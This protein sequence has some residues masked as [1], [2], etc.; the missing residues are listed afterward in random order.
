[1]LSIALFK[2]RG[3]ARGVVFYNLGMAISSTLNAVYHYTFKDPSIQLAIL[4]GIFF[5]ISILFL[6]LSFKYINLSDLLKGSTTKFG[7]FNIGLLVYLLLN[8]AGQQGQQG[9]WSDFSI[10]LFL[11]GIGLFFM[12]KL[13]KINSL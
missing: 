9:E 8:L 6:F 13:V 11:V 4:T 2:T 7:L 12:F 1:M 5:I 3:W 10:L